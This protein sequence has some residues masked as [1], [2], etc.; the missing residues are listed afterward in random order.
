M[1]QKNN[2]APERQPE[3]IKKKEKERQKKKSPGGDKRK[4]SDNYS[5]NCL[6]LSPVNNYTNKVYESHYDMNMITT[7]P[8]CV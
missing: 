2:L 6:R 5:V 4:R 7:A 8:P 1:S 3:A